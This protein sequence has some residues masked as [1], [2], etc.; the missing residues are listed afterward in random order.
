MPGC[1]RRGWTWIRAHELA[2]T[3]RFL[4]GLAE[5]DRRES[6]SLWQG[7]GRS[8]DGPGWCPFRPPLPIR[9]QVADALDTDYGIM[10]R[11]GLHCAPS[12]HQT[13]GTYPTGT[14]RF[15]FGWWN[16]EGEV[17]RALEALRELEGRA[18]WN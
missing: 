12:A 5:L 7:G 13:L 14:I 8:A 18:S 9:L 3:E 2:L 17:E 15:S 10:T 11:V 4:T 1:R 6:D 16:T